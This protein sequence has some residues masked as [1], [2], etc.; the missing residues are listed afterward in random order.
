SAESEERRARPRARGEGEDGAHRR[1]VRRT[2]GGERATG[3][4][5]QELE[6]VG[7]RGSDRAPDPRGT[8]SILGNLLF[9]GQR[10]APLRSAPPRWARARGVRREALGA[11]LGPTRRAP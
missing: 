8:A 5:A 3:A 10:Q 6:R 7:G 4:A 2:S 9:R 1:A 11:G